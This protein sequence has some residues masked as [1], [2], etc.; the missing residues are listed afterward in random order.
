MLP[1]YTN[2]ST[3][4]EKLSQQTACLFLCSRLIVNHFLFNCGGGVDLSICSGRPLKAC[5]SLM[6]CSDSCILSC[7]GSLSPIGHWAQHE[8]SPWGTLPG[9]P[10]GGVICKLFLSGGRE[11]GSVSC[12]ALAP[13]SGGLAV[14][15]RGWQWLMMPTL[16]NT[17]WKPCSR[18]A[19]TDARF[20]VK[21]HKTRS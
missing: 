10:L 7:A 9:Q 4:V 17:L 13:L 18:W 5:C 16:F 20:A 3:A 14:P 8:G 15:M 6:W 1:H 11:P 12:P 19:S 2:G 21:L